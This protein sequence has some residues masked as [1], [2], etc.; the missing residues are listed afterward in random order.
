MSSHQ[1]QEVSWREVYDTLHKVPRLLVLW[2]SKQVTEVAG[3]NLNQSQYKEHH[4]PHCPSCS[5]SL[6]SCGH[7]L[8]CE[9]VGRVDALLKSIDLIAIWMK[10]VGTDKEL[11]RLII[12]F[13]Q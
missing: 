9:E 3:T 1:L 13:A 11:G 4:D 8:M 7:V 5:S 12:Q 6:K 2:S 10:D